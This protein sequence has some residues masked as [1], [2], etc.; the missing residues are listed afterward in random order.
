[1]K[2]ILGTVQLGIK[3]GINNTKGKPTTQQS[4]EILE[5]AYKNNIN[6]FDT[7]QSYGSSEKI[8][9]EF[10]KDKNKNVII[11]KLKYLDNIEKSL[12]NLETDKLD[13]LLLHD[14]N[15]FENNLE[16]FLE[17]KDKYN[18]LGVSVYNVSEA[19][20]VLKN[21]NIKYLQIPINILDR[22]WEN[23]EFLKLLKDKIIIVRSIFLQG[24]LIKYNILDKLCKKFNINNRVELCISYIKSIK[25]IDGLIIGVDD[26]EQ[27]KDNIKLFNYCRILNNQELEII[28]KE[29]KNVPNKILDPR[30][31]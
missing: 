25:W 2:L 10:N 31:W 14:Y 26:I 20:N 12:E 1:M 17:M 21:E 5:Y 9:G 23:K 18:Y 19:I 7:A 27:L 3:Y 4:L 16:W 13:V 24:Y 29:F 22:Q 6:I 15:D 8:L 11:T 28:K 30:L